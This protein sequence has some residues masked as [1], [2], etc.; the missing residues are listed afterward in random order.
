VSFL[1][2]FVLPVSGHFKNIDND[3]DDDDDDV[4][5]VKLRASLASRDQQRN[6]NKRP[7]SL[8]SISSSSSSGSSGFAGGLAAF[9]C[10][11]AGGLPTSAAAAP[12]STLST[13]HESP[14]ELLS[15]AADQP[16]T[17]RD[18]RSLEVEEILVGGGA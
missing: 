11:A 17:S 5:A 12:L 15:A 16:G 1:L 3:D 6:G 2:L 13:M 8:V 14:L 10:H 4:L 7:H 18:Q 9:H